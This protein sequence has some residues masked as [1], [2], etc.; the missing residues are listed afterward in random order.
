MTRPRRRWPA[1]AAVLVAV[2]LGA[3]REAHANGRYPSTNAFFFSPNEPDRILLR[4]TF[5][6]LVTTDRG[7]SWDWVCEPALRLLGDEDPMYAITPSGAVV[8][9]TFHG[10]DVSTDRLCTW[11][12]VG[13]PIGTKVFVDLTSRPAAPSDIVVFSSSR[14]GDGVYDSELF[15]TKDEAKT[16]VSL[17][18]PFPDK[19]FLGETVDIAPSD[20]DRLYVT[21]V[22]NKGAD[23]RSTHVFASRDH[24]KTWT[25]TA[26]PLVNGET[27]LFIAGVDPKNAD[28]VYL[29][30]SNLFDQPTRLLVSDDAG[31]TFRAV[32]TAKSPLAGFALSPD[33]ARVYVGGAADGLQVASTSDFAFTQRS[34]IEIQCL[35]WSP[36]GLYACSNERFGFVAGL[37]RDEGATFTPV[38]RF[39]DIRG[40]LQGCAFGS[41][42]Q[43][44]CVQGGKNGKPPWPFQRVQLA[45]DLP[46]GGGGGG[47][48][49]GAD[50][51]AAA[52]P[53]L[54]D[55]GCRVS[56]TGGAS[57]TLLGL[58]A[59]FI[60]AAVARVAAR[61]RRRAD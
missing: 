2:A 40:P 52:S 26:I 4:V 31:K 12:A 14:V 38:L 57:S 21:G 17:G 20:P 50:A 59:A 32:F 42:T 6:L 54:E 22:K 9:S 18:S 43:L 35:A 7:K 10:V 29:R 37:S 19:S 8:T 61:T 48:D 33:G 45:C 55:D 46:D 51:G 23:D 47:R 49:A 36:D 15:E 25:T 24:G 60:A 11:P 3:P 39:C 1:L 56:P 53:E 30:T 16:F 44:E 58:S 34:T 27:S 13:A 5:G 41:A 28:R